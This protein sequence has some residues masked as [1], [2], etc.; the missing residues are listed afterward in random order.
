MAGTA[1]NQKQSTT[2][3]VIS[4]KAAVCWKPGERLVIEQID[5]APP[6]AG[7][8][9]I[10]ITHATVC[11]SDLTLLK[12]QAM[13]ALFP[14]IVGHEA[15]GIVESVGDGVT[16]LEPGDHVL[17][18]FIG[19]CKQCAD[20]KSNKTNLCGVYGVNALKGTML[21][22]N[23]SRFSLNG[24]VIFHGFTSA[25]SEY[26]VV[27]REH[28]V[29]I[30]P[31][32][33]LNT[34]LLLSCGAAAGLGSV[35]NVAKVEEGASVAILGLGTVGMGVAVGAR[36][37]KASRI[38]GVDIN[39]S[40]AEEGKKF[41]VTDFL[42]PKNFEKPIDEVIKEMTNGGVDYAFECAGVPSLMKTAFDSCRNGWGTAIIAG[43]TRRGVTMEV[44]PF[45]LL[46]GQ[47]LKGSMYGGWKPQSDIPE[48]VE[49]SLRNEFDLESFITHKLPFSDI[50]DAIKLLEDG[51]S[52]RTVLHL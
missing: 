21:G 24:Q 41:G 15:S 39:D 13:S 14:R 44:E 11:H 17:P 12:A 32:A 1:A 31:V 5:V 49:K 33:P 20:C 18:V 34:A 29:K 43:V 50:N 36:T 45:H 22:D 46:R 6:K 40:K 7:E 2:G 51:K 10:R 35:W 4:C 8:V 23:T 16:D 37:A 27:E 52:L 19:E 47:T 9:R 3:K 42:N 26:T 30:N 48:L 38:I 28:V 25:F